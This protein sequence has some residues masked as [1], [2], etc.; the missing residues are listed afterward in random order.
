[1]S[2]NKPTE[3]WAALPHT[4]AKI[5]ILEKY[6][7]VYFQ[8]LGL[9]KAGQDMLYIDGFAGPNTYTNLPYG[10]PGAALKA[11]NDA[12]A[13]LTNIGK[14]WKAGGIDFVF[15]EKTPELYS[16]LNETLSGTENT[17]EIRTQCMG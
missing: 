13:A 10:S 5:E 14:T 1:M 7:T 2:A 6:L 3:P 16:I 11:A 9:S 15:V 4:I 17:P 8:I 12:R